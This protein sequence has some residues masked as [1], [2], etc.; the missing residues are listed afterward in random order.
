MTIE[1]S[2]RAISATPARIRPLLSTPGLRAA[3]Y[4]VKN[5]VNALAN[6]NTSAS[7]I[8]AGALSR[9]DLEAKVVK[10]R[11]SRQTGPEAAQRADAT[12]PQ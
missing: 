2:P 5:F 6:P 12:V 9:I 7:G 3:Q 1:N 8:T 10:R 4:P 11:T